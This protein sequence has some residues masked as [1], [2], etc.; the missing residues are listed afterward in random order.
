MRSH[1]G[2][3]IAAGLALLFSATTAAANDSVYTDMNLDGCE[4][5]HLEEDISVTMR[6]KGPA[7]YPF[8]FKEGDLRQ[9]VLFGPVK[10]SYVDQ[11]FETFGTFNHT[12]GK[13]EWRLDAKGRPIAAI[14][15]YILEHSAPDGG[16]PSDAYYGQVLV[17]SR[18][19]QE[20][21]GLGCMAGFVD[22]KATKSANRVA[23]QVADAVAPGFRCG[24][25]T[26]VYYGKRGDSA[27]DLISVLPE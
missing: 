6:C 10:Q 24:I 3:L 11:A 7:G 4:T 12:G 21:D 16:A 22:A 13:A 14:L 1:D 25:D 8:Y 17:I 23:R 18:V 2:F 9:T 15:R 19:A 5:V 20:R 27:D 26:P